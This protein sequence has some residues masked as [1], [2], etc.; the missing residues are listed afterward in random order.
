MKKFLILFTLFLFP[1]QH[2]G[3]AIILPTAEII[4]LKN[5]I[6]ED[7]VF[8][9]S[10][11]HPSSPIPYDEFQI[12]TQGNSGLYNTM[13]VTDYQNT[14]FRIYENQQNGWHMQDVACTSDSLENSFVSLPSGIELHIDVFTSTTCVFTNVRT[15]PIQPVMIVP[16]V[17]GTDLKRGD[18]IL[19][20]DPQ[21]MVNDIGDE[22]MDPLGFEA[23]LTPADDQVVNSEI[24]RSKSFLFFNFDYTQGLLNEFASQNYFENQQVFTFP[25]DWRYGV[26]GRFSDGTTNVD[27]LQE[28]IQEI[29]TQT[30]SDKIDVI[31][32][33][34]GGLL[35]KKYV[36]DHLDNHHINKAVFVGVPNTGAPKAIKTLVQGDNFGIIGLSDEE[37][38]KIAQ[39][40]PVVYDL[41][42]SEKY[43]STAGS[44]YKI[45]TQNA[46][47]MVSEIQLLDYDETND[48]LI[49]KGMNSQAIDH[50]RDLHTISFDN[51]DL[52]DAGVD[53]YNIVGCKAD[54]ITSVVEKQVKPLFGQTFSVF[55]APQTRPGDGT[56]PLESATN[57]PVDASKKFYTLESNHS[58]MLSLNGIRQQI[59][60]IIADSSLPVNPV[61]V[62]QDF[63][64]CNTKQR[65]MYIY[66]PLDIE[67]IDEQGNR[68]GKA[69]DGSLQN[70]IPNAGFYVFG[71]R[72][73]LFL[74]TE[75]TQYYDIKLVGTDDSSFTLKTQEITHTSG[76]RILGQM[77]VFADIPILTGTAGELS[78]TGET[79]I[80]QFDINGD[81]TVDQTI[82]PSVI[83]DSNQSQDLVSPTTFATITGTEGQAGFYRSNVEITLTAEDPVIPGEETATS[84]V[85]KTYY[86]LDEGGLQEYVSPFIVENPGQHSLSYYSVDRAGNK[87]VEQILNFVI[88]KIP[89]EAEIVFDVALRD[90]KI[91]GIDEQ[92]EPVTMT[93]DDRFVILTDQAGNTTKLEFKEKSRKHSLRD[94]LVNIYYNDSNQP[95]NKNW[96]LFSWL[97]DKKGKL[98]I[99]EQQILSK[100]D[101][102]ITAIFMER[103]NQ[104]R[105]TK[106]E[107]RKTTTKIILGLVI[108]KIRTSAGELE[109][110]I[111]GF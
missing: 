65:A 39:N 108:L 35:V 37:M 60:N 6:G 5:T 86:Q 52:R 49:E 105:V 107:D 20:V 106:R 73:F 83:L 77:E 98:Q 62:T 68:L 53:L 15:N 10:I 28:K 51:F 71:E 111:P 100:K 82:Q 55:D 9:F 94:E 2:V 89:P 43:F 21:K 110:S 90:L 45:V 57:L 31:A 64:K 36:M 103:K 80:I 91:T 102:L 4:I 70:D 3:A 17:L 76:E 14:T 26:S 95:V 13:V 41:S 72:K 34:T 1:F 59:V 54:T 75:N 40:L 23:D 7:G 11:Y 24:I 101:F 25:Y 58:R 30:G 29:L 19:W 109:Y 50:A 8:D 69:P 27:K 84:G 63:N 97:F 81:G 16:G 61:I 66:S 56:V 46:F 48:F 44:Y 99:L 74:P 67:V 47:G 18:E 42:P 32:H 79:P 78:F 87:E 38:K 12:S 22:F 93:E 33:S 92:S 88:D 96:F 104:T 85:F